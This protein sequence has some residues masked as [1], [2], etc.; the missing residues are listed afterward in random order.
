MELEKKSWMFL[1]NTTSGRHDE[2]S[3][4]INGSLFVTGGGISIKTHDL[5]VPVHHNKS[6]M[7]QILSRRSQN[8]T[9]STKPVEPDQTL[10]LPV[11]R[12]YSNRGP[13]QI[14]AD[15]NTSQNVKASPC[16]LNDLVFKNSS[17]MEIFRRLAA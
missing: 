2:S 3:V 4:A 13:P 12:M 1:T 15:S 10:T 9:G 7:E 5:Q 16:G 8:L 6:T 11:Y 17:N 14:E